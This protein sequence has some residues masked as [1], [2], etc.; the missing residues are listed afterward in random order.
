M[1]DLKITA[2]VCDPQIFLC[3]EV[4][5]CE[6]S[7]VLSPGQ[8]SWKI[9]N[10]EGILAGQCRLNLLDKGG[11]L[12]HPSAL[13]TDFSNL[14]LEEKLKIDNAFIS[15]LDPHS[16]VSWIRPLKSTCQWPLQLTTEK[17]SAKF[18]LKSR[19]PENLPP[20]YRGHIIRFAYKVLIKVDVENKPLQL[21]RLPLRILPNVTSYYPMDST[22]TPAASI[23][24]PMSSSYGSQTVSDLI[25]DPFHMDFNAQV[26]QNNP[27]SELQRGSMHQAVYEKL[28]QFYA[29][30]QVSSSISPAKKSEKTR[31]RRARKTSLSHS[32]SAM[33]AEI[34]SANSLAAF[35]ISAPNGHICRIGIF[36]TVARLGDSLRG[37][38]DFRSATL[39]SFE[40]VIRA[41]TNEYFDPSHQ[42]DIYPARDLSF[43]TV[44][45]D[46]PA[47]SKTKALKLPENATNTT[48]FETSLVCSNTKFLP[49][50]IPLPLNGPADFML[51]SKYWNGVCRVQ[52]CLRF[53]FIVARVKSRKKSSSTTDSALYNL[54]LRDSPVLKNPDFVP[55]IDCDTQT[56]PW[57]LPVCVIP[58]GPTAFLL[59]SY[60]VASC[61]FMEN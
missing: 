4:L 3:G 15:K 44:P 49:F 54:F 1:Y 32:P 36:K 10:I 22:S 39:P 52:W 60:S 25:S 45:I 6:V 21:L 58:N 17:P 35:T 5:R 37:Y 7:A 14:S 8:S 55:S 47:A 28:C 59:P 61:D 41:D 29:N 31:K 53:E 16:H 46:V 42:V 19:L 24:G 40:C 9:R 11:L 20:S 34:V 50:S 57:E 48:W 56:F 2:Q 33:F 38:L 23:L 18:V 13:V 27:L 43:F 51:A 26:H 30:D 12:R